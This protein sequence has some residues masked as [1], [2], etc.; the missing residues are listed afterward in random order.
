MY[1]LDRDWS[2]GNKMVKYEFDI[3]LLLVIPSKLLII[4]FQF[5]FNDN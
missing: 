3:S 4:F 5:S 2:L 1:V